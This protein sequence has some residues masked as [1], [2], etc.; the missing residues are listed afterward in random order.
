MENNED[1]FDK[2]FGKSQSS[3]YTGGVIYNGYQLRKLTNSN[4]KPFK[5]KKI[6]HSKE[7]LETLS[8]LKK[9]I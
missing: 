2:T 9:L 6:E 1:Y 3:T 8:R 5:G 7:F 4:V